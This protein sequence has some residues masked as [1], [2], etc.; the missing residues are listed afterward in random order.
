M[1]AMSRTRTEVKSVY[2]GFILAWFCLLFM[3]HE[4][5]LP[6]RDVSVR[7]LVVLCALAASAIAAGFVLRRRL[8]RLSTDALP[9]DPRKAGQF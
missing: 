2:D 1:A 9:H 4:M 8:F 3:I 6:R 7:V 5:N